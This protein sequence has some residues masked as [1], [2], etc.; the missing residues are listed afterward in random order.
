M[1]RAFF[2]LFFVVL[3]FLPSLAC[4]YFQ[5]ESV[6]GSGNIISQTIDVGG[7]DQVT[8]E[9]SGNVHIEQGQTESLSVKM[10]DNLVRFLDIKVSGNELIL[11]IKRG[12][13]LNPSQTIVYNLTVKDLRNITLAGSGSFDIERLQLNDLR[14]SLPGSGDIKIESLAAK[15]LDIDLGGS[16]SITLDNINVKLI[17][18]ALRGSGDIELHG[19]TKEEKVVVRGSGNYWAE[20]LQTKTAHVSIPGSA[21]VTLWV[22]KELEIRINGSGDIQY[23]G[24]PVVYQAGSG[25]CEI[26]PMGEK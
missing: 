5:T 25:S 6:A 4:G 24:Q 23:Y 21:D 16:G 26:T 7:F 18:T 2:S 15:E 13:D 8:L 17:D 3:F 9:G 1:K 12:L 11:G 10:D 20:D 22:T 14:I 19:I